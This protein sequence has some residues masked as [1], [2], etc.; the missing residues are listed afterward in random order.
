M[1]FISM[2]SSEISD[3]IPCTVNREK[4]IILW[5]DSFNLF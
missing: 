5:H 3:Q 2:G 1:G 4:Y